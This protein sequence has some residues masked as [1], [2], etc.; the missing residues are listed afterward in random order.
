MD[1]R[2]ISLAAAFALT[3]S[4]GM[5]HAAAGEGDR[6]L[7]LAGT[8]ASDKDFDNNSAGVTGELGW[9][10]SDQWEVGVRQ[11]VNVFSQDGDGSDWSGA[12]RAFADYHFGSGPFQP[13]VGVSLG[14]IYGEH[15]KDTGFGGPEVGFKQWVKDDVYLELQVE[16]QFLFESAG[17][18]DDNFDDGALAY[19]FGVGF[20]F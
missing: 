6:T 20:T 19:T 11:S 16:Y 8:G 18:I 14:A 10:L 15:V 4:G 7:T 1:N 5:A 17:D 9:F 13:F 12:T 3:V 2:W